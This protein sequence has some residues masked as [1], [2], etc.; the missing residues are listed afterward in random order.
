VKNIWW[1]VDV[2]NTSLCSFF[3]IFC[4]LVPLSHKYSP[5]HS[6]LKNSQ[7]TFLRECEW[8]RFSH[9]Q[10]QDKILVLCSSIYIFLDTVLMLGQRITFLW[11]CITLNFE[12]VRGFKRLAQI[13]HSRRD[14]IHQRLTLNKATVKKCNFA[15]HNTLIF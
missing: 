7:P 10:K 11:N 15:F 2:I 6:I 14:N 13:Y 1:T 12:V 3:P 4:Y 5:Q 9:I 8:Q